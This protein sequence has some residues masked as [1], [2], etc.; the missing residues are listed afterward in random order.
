MFYLLPPGLSALYE[1]V[2][3]KSNMFAGVSVHKAIELELNWIACHIEHLPGVRL[4]SACSWDPS[5]DDIVIAHV[6]AATSTGLGIYFPQLDLAFQCAISELPPS[7]HI[8]YLELLA[9]SSAVHAATKMDPPP[10]HLAVFSDSSFAVDVFNTLCAKPGF[11]TIVMAT[12][13]DLINHGIDLRVV[14]V[15]GASNS[16]ADAISRFNNQAA[17]TLVPDLSILPFLPPRNVLGAAQ[18]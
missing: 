11:N 16:V 10:T 18:Q 5:E 9:V 17:Q 4:L 14:H 12:V 7:S 8:N 3:G 2:L 13:D 1:K 6:D 15:A